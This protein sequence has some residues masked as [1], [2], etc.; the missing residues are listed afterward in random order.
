MGLRASFN[1]E[2]LGYEMETPQLGLEVD[3]SEGIDVFVD[4]FLYTAQDLVPVDTGNLMHSIDAIGDDFGAECWTNCHYSQYVEYGTI[5]MK[6]QPYFVPAIE[7][8]LNQAKPLWD[9]AW[10][11]AIAEE[12]EML[13][14][15]GE[16]SDEGAS[17]G[18][19]GG[20]MGLLG[21]IAL[22]IANAIV[23]SL[24]NIA[25]D[26]LTGGQHSQSGGGLINCIDI[27]IT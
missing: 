3:Y 24:I 13:A 22:A 25:E 27:E 8:A 17:M 14:E 18:D 26:I 7:K 1:M 5:K 19:F 11:E 16:E 2:D 6:A 23:Q 9:E 12:E 15:M 10:D 20:G 4:T 21:M